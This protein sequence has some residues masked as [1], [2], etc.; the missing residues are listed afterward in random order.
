[1]LFPLRVCGYYHSGL[2]YVNM[3]LCKFLIY[4][5]TLAVQQ[6]LSSSSKLTVFVGNKVCLV[7]QRA[8]TAEE[9]CYL[10]IFMDARVYIYISLLDYVVSHG[11]LVLLIVS[12]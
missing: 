5:L 2:F 11:T 9:R 3:Q 4:Y 8:R 7:V 12:G 1:M 6:W 10:T